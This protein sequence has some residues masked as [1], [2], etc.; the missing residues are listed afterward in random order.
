MSS[1]NINIDGVNLKGIITN[2]Q[3][4]YPSPIEIRSWSGESYYSTDN[5]PITLKITI[6]V[7]PEQREK[8]G[9]IYEGMMAT[10][11]KTFPA[12]TSDYDRAMEVLS[13]K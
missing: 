8:I 9:K 3:M 1:N 10:Y 4:D 13:R 5:A 7:Y 11:D 6:N 12:P 2:L